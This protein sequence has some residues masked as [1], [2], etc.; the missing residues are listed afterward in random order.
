[1]LIGRCYGKDQAR[2]H[3]KIE[4]GLTHDGLDEEISSRR[5]GMLQQEISTM[6]QTGVAGS[7]RVRWGRWQDSPPESSFVPENLS[8]PDQIVQSACLEGTTSKS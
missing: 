8:L 6:T 5:I 4:I 7:G 3:K 1:M 2:L